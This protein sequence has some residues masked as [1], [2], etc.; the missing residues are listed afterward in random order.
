MA[1]LPKIGQLKPAPN[2]TIDVRV[3]ARSM[4]QCSFNW[5]NGTAHKAANTVIT[6]NCSPTN[7]PLTQANLFFKIKISCC[8]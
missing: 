4:S 7:K 6:E 3:P 8:L 5:R 2:K 1:S